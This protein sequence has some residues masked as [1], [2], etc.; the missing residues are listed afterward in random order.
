MCSLV[1]EG[2]VSAIAIESSITAEHAQMARRNCGTLLLGGADALR[3]AHLCQSQAR[4]PQRAILRGPRRR[5]P[6]RLG[7]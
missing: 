5:G 3:L 6:K 2:S 7:E 1:D 4:E